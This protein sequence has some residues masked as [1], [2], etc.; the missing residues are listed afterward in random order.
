[1]TNPAYHGQVYPVRALL[2]D[3]VVQIE[4]DVG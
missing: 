4:A 1:M 2:I 3:D